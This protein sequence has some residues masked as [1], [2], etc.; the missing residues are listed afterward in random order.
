MAKLINL[1]KIFCV[2]KKIGKNSK[3]TKDVFFEIIQTHQHPDEGTCTMSLYQK[4]IQ[5]CKELNLLNETP[6]E[7]E[8][9]NYGEKYYELIPS[10]SKE[11]LFD[12]KRRNYQ[13]LAQVFC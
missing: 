4:H 9:T 5:I 8:M 12:E 6:T 11:K 13:L 2:I 1:S 7:L 3:I 10:D